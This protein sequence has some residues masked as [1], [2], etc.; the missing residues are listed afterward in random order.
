MALT[1][2]HVE[3]ALLQADA[4]FQ[5]CTT[6]LPTGHERAINLF[7]SAHDLTPLQAC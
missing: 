7:N 4:V 1:V 6:S 2:L 3:M 5:A